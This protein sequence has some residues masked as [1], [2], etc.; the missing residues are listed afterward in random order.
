MPVKPPLVTMKLATVEELMMKAGP[1]MPFGL[2]E[3]FAHGVVVPMPM[4]PL[5]VKVPA[6]VVVALPPT[7]RMVETYW[8]VL[9]AFVVVAFQ[10]ERLV[11]VLEAWFTRMPPR[12]IEL[13]VV[14][15]A[16]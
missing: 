6:L 15:V 9:V 10:S 14:E 5:V 4:E 8:F 13:R 1:V 3:S 2:M 7:V 16:R 11:M 12:K